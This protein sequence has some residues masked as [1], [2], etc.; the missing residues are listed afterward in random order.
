[1][2]HRSWLTVI[3]DQRQW[4]TFNKITEAEKDSYFTG[5]SYA[6]EITSENSGFEKGD[7]IIAW[8]SDSRPGKMLETFPKTILLDNYLSQVPEWNDDPSQFGNFFDQMIDV[9]KYLF[10]KEKPEH[11]ILNEKSDNINKSKNTAMEKLKIG[12]ARTHEFKSGTTVYDAGL[13]KSKLEGVPVND[14]GFFDASIVTEGDKFII[15][16]GKVPD[17]IN[18]VL[19]KEKIEKLPENNGF[20]N[21]VVA[22]KSYKDQENSQNPVNEFSVYVPGKDGKEP[23][24]LG[25]GRLASSNESLGLVFKETIR[26]KNGAEFFTYDMVIDK[27]T[28]LAVPPSDKHKDAVYINIAPVKGRDDLFYAYPSKDPNDTNSILTVNLEHSKLSLVN[29]NEKGESRL[30]I[31]TKPD[32]YIV[33]DNANFYVVDSSTQNS[34]NPLYVGKG[35]DPEH[36][37]WKNNPEKGQDFF[38][39]AGDVVQFK[40]NDNYYLNSSMGVKDHSAFGTF[41]GFTEDGKLRVES[42]CGNFNF[43]KSNIRKSDMS[44]LENFNNSYEAL[45]NAKK[46]EKN[47]QKNSVKVQENVSERSSS[48]VKTNEKKTPVKEKGRSN[49]FNR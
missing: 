15:Y 33:K 29:E 25:W 27:Q 18:L 6:I 14:K 37:Y 4:K 3:E 8:N 12:N 9:D 2:G 10:L 31:K 46:E 49:D 48:N 24:Y 41:T 43:D 26:P 28:L 1:M 22:P 21:F 20:S 40:V 36:M 32:K 7:V 16:E 35:W 5:I 47:K 19:N 44:S 30:T 38:L 13:Q 42:V 39:Q 34:D 23:N 17:S 45:V 11:N